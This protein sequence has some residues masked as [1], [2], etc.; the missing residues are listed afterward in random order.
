MF[1]ALVHLILRDSKRRYNTMGP[2]NPTA[3]CLRL[4]WHK[5]CPRKVQKYLKLLRHSKRKSHV[6]LHYS[7]TSCATTFLLQ[8]RILRA[9]RLCRGQDAIADTFS[10][11]TNKGMENRIGMGIRVGNAEVTIAQSF[12]HSCQGQGQLTMP[13]ACRNWS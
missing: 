12:P 1:R 4:S 11:E 13:I 8:S 2:R 9:K 3:G 5:P 6:R 7:E 10:H